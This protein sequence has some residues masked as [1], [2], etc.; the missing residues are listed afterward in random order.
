MRRNIMY[1]AASRGA[2]L[3][4]NITFQLSND[5]FLIFFVEFLWGLLKFFGVEMNN[6]N[7]DK[8]GSQPKFAGKL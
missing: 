3:I 1:A 6:G 4:R 5:S 8:R 2:T 7:V